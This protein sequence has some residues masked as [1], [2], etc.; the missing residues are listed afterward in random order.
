MSL[1]TPASITLADLRQCSD[2]GTKN[3]LD[4]TFRMLKVIFRNIYDD[5]SNNN[6]FQLNFD[7]EFKF[8]SGIKVKRT[9]ISATYTALV[10]DFLIAVTST[11]AARTINLPA[12]ATAGAGKM[13]FIKDE[14]GGAA[15]NNITIDP[16]GAELIDG[17][18]TKLI[19]TNYG[20]MRIYC[21]G[22]AWFTI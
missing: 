2:A 14:S 10:N 11:A 13:Y 22:T 9:A 6:V 18:A 1:K 7:Y 8:L 17:A 5:L 16:S 19:N 20:A 21:N 12:A 4:Q 15:A 3:V